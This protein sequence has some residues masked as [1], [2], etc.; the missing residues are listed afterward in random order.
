MIAPDGDG[1]HQAGSLQAAIDD[2]QGGDHGVV[3]PEQAACGEQEE[4]EDDAAESPEGAAQPS[5]GER[6]A[7]WF[8]WQ[9]GC[10]RFLRQLGS[11]SSAFT[12]YLRG[13]PNAIA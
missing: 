6:R 11:L 7:N 5:S 13:T 4:Q 2:R 9:A 8:G 1:L 12:G 10:G 3:Q